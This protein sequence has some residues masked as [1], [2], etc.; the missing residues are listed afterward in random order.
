LLAQRKR[1]KRKGS[2][3]LDPQ[4]ADYLALLTKSRRFGKS[5]L[6][7]ESFLPLFAVLLSCVKWQNYSKFSIFLIFRGKNSTPSGGWHKIFT[8]LL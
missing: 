6:S 7:A 8:V 2:P 1:I 4:Y 5:I 3:S